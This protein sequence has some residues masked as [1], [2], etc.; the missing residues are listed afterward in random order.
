[1]YVT[2]KQIVRKLPTNF[3]LISIIQEAI[4]N[5]IQAHATHIK[6]NFLTIPH[7][8]LE[9]SRQVKNIIIEDNGDGFTDDNINSFNNYLSEYKLDLGCKGIGR[10]TYL[11]I[12]D[13]IEIA[14]YNK[15]QNITFD[16][17][18]NTEL[19]HPTTNTDPLKKNTSVKFCNVQNKE[20]STSLDNERKDIINHFLSIFKFISDTK[21]ELIIEL[22]LDDIYKHSINAQE[23]GSGFV[24]KT[25]DVQFGD[26]KETFIVSYKQQG[27]SIKGF[28]CAN[29]RSVQEDG[30]NINLRTSKDKGLLFFVRSNFFDQAVNDE[31]NEFN[32]KDN[33]K[34][35][36]SLDWDTINRH[37]FVAVNEVCKSLNIHIEEITNKNKRESLN[38]APYLASYIRKSKN[39]STSAEII[40]EAKELFNK[41]KDYIRDL[42][43]KKN[44]DY[45]ERLCISNQAELAEYIFDREKIIKDIKNTL[46]DP[47]TKTNETLIHNKI[48][49]TKTSNH[50]YHSYK[51][52]NLWLF[53]ERFMIYTY[54]YSDKTINEILSLND[55][56]KN[57]RPDICIFTKSKEDVKDIIIIELKG[58]DAT[59]EKNASGINELNKYT[60]KIKDYFE[61]NDEKVRIWAYL[62]T[63]LNDETRQE[64]E[65]FPGMKQ[66]YTTKGKMYYL[67]NE[68]LDSITHILTLETMLEDAMSRNQLFLDILR[69]DYE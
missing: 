63:S 34:N 47:S 27:A 37:L 33:D 30:L 18:L 11:T 44:P 61:K 10:F 42:R 12:C 52:N 55:A 2:T 32:I 64:I 4:T 41:D 56:D 69:G 5:S 50:N 43:N 51:D 36:V 17:T 29:N 60:R 66:T 67:Y 39:M 49:R 14:S 46:E 58:S 38:S 65:D 16:F 20:I 48:M 24:D 68:K 57:K 45:E 7:S 59:G 9:D 8:L 26:T 19:I 53:D 40:K 25:F 21:K 23:F 15:D 35:L 1:M 62:I 31:R 54:A 3:R 28:Y 6:I 13:R 22:S